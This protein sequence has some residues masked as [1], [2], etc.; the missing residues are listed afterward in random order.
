MIP[1]HIFFVG[2]IG[3]IKQAILNKI[4]GTVSQKRFIDT[5]NLLLTPETAMVWA[6][7]RLRR[8][9]S[10]VQRLESD[11][12]S[13][14]KRIRK[15]SPSKN[16]KEWDAARKQ[17]TEA[18]KDLESSFR[19]EMD[20]MAQADLQ[21]E[22]TFNVVTHTVYEQLVSALQQAQRAGLD[23][24][25]F[26]QLRMKLS[27]L[28]QRTEKLA[29]D[30]RLEERRQARA[31]VVFQQWSLKPTGWVLRSARRTAKRARREF[32]KGTAELA[33]LAT[34]F[35]HGDEEAFMNLFIQIT[36]AAQEEIVDLEVVAEDNMVLSYRIRKQLL[37]L[38]STID[39]MPREAYQVL[40]SERQK[41]ASL[42]AYQ[43]EKQELVRKSMAYAYQKI[44]EQLDRIRV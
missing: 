44:R 23:P 39:G 43:Q 8:L 10:K 17:L 9:N 35:E 38:Q 34:S 24:A 22:S 3:T 20:A 4:I 29:D 13:M 6:E 31:A 19:P 21:L 2:P 11:V 40:Q 42:L 12:E 36:Q 32:R 5:K 27:E 37:D 1:F 18:L 30:L 25:L 26:G 7:R 15:V 28:E 14:L 16:P 41:I 33:E